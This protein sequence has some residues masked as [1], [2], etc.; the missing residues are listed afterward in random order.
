M[1]L[2]GPSENPYDTLHGCDM[3]D[4]WLR[5]GEGFCIYIGG[6]VGESFLGAR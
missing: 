6:T 2:R 4:L 5:H 1:K 3:Q